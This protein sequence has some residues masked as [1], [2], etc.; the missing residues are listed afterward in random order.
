MF[1]WI[2]QYCL[3]EWSPFPIPLVWLAWVIQT[4]LAFCNDRFAHTKKNLGQEQHGTGRYYRACIAH[5]LYSFLSTPPQHLQGT[6][7][8]KVSEKLLN[9]Q[10]NWIEGSPAN[11]LV[12]DAWELESN[13]RQMGRL[14]AS[15]TPVTPAL[16]RGRS[17][18]PAPHPRSFAV[19]ELLSQTLFSG[20]FPHGPSSP[21][22]RSEWLS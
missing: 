12:R 8:K 15:W 4:Q 11:A 21:S 2:S 22:L 14:P 20:Q 9:L 6:P 5:G 17:T 3:G 1:L 18:L 13:N 19:L 10:K 16:G 7:L